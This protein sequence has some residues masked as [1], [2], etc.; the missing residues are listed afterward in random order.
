MEGTTILLVQ[1]DL[2][3]RKLLS[4]ALHE[5]GYGVLE[6]HSGS[7]AL[8]VSETQSGRIDL[9][10]ADC[11]MPGISGLE[12]VDQ[13]RRTRPDLA[14]VMLSDSTEETALSHIRGLPFVQKPFDPSAIAETIERTLGQNGTG[15]N[16]QGAG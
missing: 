1:E 9:V 11:T 4:E 13:L 3:A 7:D 6:A 14:V 12:L 5:Q 16:L 8:H 15:S 2:P 10:L